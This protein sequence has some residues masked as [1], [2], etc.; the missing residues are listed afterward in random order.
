LNQPPVALFATFHPEGRL[1]Q[2]ASFLS[3]DAQNVMVTVLKEAEDGDGIILRAFETCGAAAHA[4][5]ELPAL[6]RT[7]EADF[8]PA[9]IKTFHIPHDALQPVTERNMLEW[10][11][12]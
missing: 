12:D 9:E 4:C 2:A 3:V 5:I 11:D 6:E 10:M 1:P 8:G 7:L